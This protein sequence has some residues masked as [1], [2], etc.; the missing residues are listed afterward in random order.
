MDENK[1]VERRKL[2]VHGRCSGQLQ[3]LSEIE[4]P[5]SV[6]AVLSLGRTIEAIIEPHWTH[7][8]T[9]LANLIQFNL[10]PPGFRSVAFSLC[11]FSQWGLSGVFKEPKSQ[12][13]KANDFLL[14]FSCCFTCSARTQSHQ[15]QVNEIFAPTK[16]KRTKKRERKITIIANADH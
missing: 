11:R 10:I 8:H 12:I 15:T 2:V 4:W 3:T 6:G 5:P 1:P 13:A 9:G 16:R 7:R 14:Q